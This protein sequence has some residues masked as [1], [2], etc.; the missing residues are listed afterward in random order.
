MNSSRTSDI[1]SR[2]A[3]KS[4]VYEDDGFFSDVP[5]SGSLSRSLIALNKYMRKN[6]LYEDNVEVNDESEDDAY[7]TKESSP[8]DSVSKCDTDSVVSSEFIEKQETFLENKNSEPKSPELY[9]SP[10]EN[11]TDQLTDDYK[12]KS[13]QL[14][15]KPNYN[16][17]AVY[18]GNSDTRE[19]EKV[20]DIP[21]YHP[22]GEMIPL[23]NSSNNNTCDKEFLN[24]NEKQND[25]I[26]V[27][28]QSESGDS[29]QTDTETQSTQHDF[30]EWGNRT[31]IYP[32]VYAPL[33]YSEYKS[34][35]IHVPRNLT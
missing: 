29:I 23:H 34:L 8:N 9:D 11:T 22:K 21:N 33:P 19:C 17:D 26:G 3:V 25:D 27:T 20:P 31:N 28:F 1:K 35:F 10:N 5:S 24:N 18:V 32:D 12:I 13:M 2:R 16:F 15:D 14:L 4:E 30:T 6:L 7:F